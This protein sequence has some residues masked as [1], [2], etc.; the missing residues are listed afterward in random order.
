MRDEPQPER[1]AGRCRALVPG[2]AGG[3][4]ALD[5]AHRAR[6]PR[7]VTAV[8]ERAERRDEAA[9]AAHGGQL[10]SARREADRARFETTTSGPVNEAGGRHYRL[11]RAVA[12]R[13]VD[14][15]PPAA[16]DDG[17]LDR[18]TGPE[19]GHDPRDVVGAADGLS[20]DR[21]DQVAAERDVDAVVR[22][23]ARP[24]AEPGAGGGRP[25]L[26]PGDERAAL[27]AEV[28]RARR[29]RA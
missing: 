13:D 17:E 12:E 26:D 8:D 28:E 24:A 10:P 21:D 20:G 7:D 18:L 29:S 23:G 25:V 27:G 14:R 2:A 19:L 6:D 15:R 4:L 3:E 9:G 1:R 11:E 5:V 16:A 22:L